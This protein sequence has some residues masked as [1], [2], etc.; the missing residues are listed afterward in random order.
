MENTE[1]PKLHFHGLSIVGV[2]FLVFA[3]STQ[4]VQVTLNV[5]AKLVPMEENS[6]EF[7]ILMDVEVTAPDQWQI[8]VSGF[9]D[10]EFRDDLENSRKFIDMNAPAIMF[11]YFRAF[12]AT[13]TSNAGGSVPTITIPPRFFHGELEELQLEQK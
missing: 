2:Q 9:G 10:F 4:D 1:S 7:R 11:P 5:D 13:L 8:K 12:I 6:R 3:T